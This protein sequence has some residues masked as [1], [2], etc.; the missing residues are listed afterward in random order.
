M[1]KDKDFIIRTYP[2]KGLVIFLSIV[3]GVCLLVGV[4]NYF[5]I[6]DILALQIVIWIFCGVFLILSLIVLLKEAIVYIYFDEKAKEIVIQDFLHKKK[7]RLDELRRVEVKDGF[8]I[9]FKGNKEFYRMG[10]ER[11]GANNLV[12]ALEKNGANIKW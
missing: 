10:T 7:I 8:Y 6:K 11:T 2:V 3:I 1:K 5:L 12:V 9:F 4:G